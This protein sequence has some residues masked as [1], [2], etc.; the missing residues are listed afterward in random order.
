VQVSLDR[1]EAVEGGS[2]GLAIHA[3]PQ[4]KGGVP[5]RVV[6]LLEPTSR[7]AGIAQLRGVRPSGTTWTALA[8]PAVRAQ[9]QPTAPAGSEAGG[10]AVRALLCH[11]CWWAGPGSGACLRGNAQMVGGSDHATQ[12]TTTVEATQS[13]RERE[14]AHRK[15]TDRRVQLCAWH[16]CPCETHQVSKETTCERS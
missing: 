1:R 13:A 16:L 6:P 8:T 3:E 14:R 10:R 2:C 7:I 4:R 12:S 5:I 15:T 11:H 9:P